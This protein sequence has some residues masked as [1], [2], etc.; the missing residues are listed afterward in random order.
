MPKV[1]INLRVYGNFEEENKVL[2]I[3]TQLLI[4]IIALLIF[5]VY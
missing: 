4:L 5:N 1:F 2:K 3:L